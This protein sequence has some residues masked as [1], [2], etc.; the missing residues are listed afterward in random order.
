MEHQLI[1]HQHLALLEWVV[2]SQILWSA[3]RVKKDPG[4]VECPPAALPVAAQHTAAPLVA[5]AVALL[6]AAASKLLSSR[7]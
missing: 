5:R 3:A 7:K 2:Q 4:L 1:E 6:A